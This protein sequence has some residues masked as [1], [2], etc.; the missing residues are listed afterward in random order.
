MGL[1]RRERRSAGDDAT[2]SAFLSSRRQSQPMEVS[3][4][5]QAMRLA[6]VWSC[7]RVLAGIGASLP[8]DQYRGGVPMRNAHLWEEPFPGQTTP[9]WM[10]RLWM[11]ILTS[12]NAY[13]VVSRANDAGMVPTSVELID[14][15]LVRWRSGGDRWITSVGGVDVDL[16]PNGPLWHLP[17][18][19]KPGVP[20]GMSPLSYAA[21]TIGAGLAASSF[22]GGFFA[23]GGHPSAILYAED[24]NLSAE[25]ADAVKKAFLRATRGNEPAVLGAGYK[26]ETVQISPADSAFIESSSLNARQ[27]A[28]ILGVPPEWIGEGVSGS[29]VTYANR[30]QRWSDFLAVDFMPYLIPIEKGLSRLLPRPQEVRANLDGVLR[31]DLATRYA[32]YKTAAE[33]FDLTGAELLTPAEMRELENR[34]PIPGATFSRRAPIGTSEPGVRA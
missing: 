1:F 19:T 14:P 25:Q 30:E 21:S 22:A 13:G 31:S 11:S 12:G 9:D 16:W 5:D 33:I 8:I 7:F 3:D 24:P 15:A 18:F 34:E 4:P 23:G 32:S 10:R 17:L 27:I 29:T 6:A 28:S 26:Y 2:L 20:W